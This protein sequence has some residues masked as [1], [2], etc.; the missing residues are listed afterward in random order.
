M[1]W[2]E[3]SLAGSPSFTTMM[4]SPHVYL[5]FFLLFSICPKGLILCSGG[6]SISEQNYTEELKEQ[7]VQ[8]FLPSVATFRHIYSNKKDTS[9]FHGAV[10]FDPI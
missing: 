9:D 8:V 7:S 10:S 2:S 1:S 6:R 3:H 5:C 4:T